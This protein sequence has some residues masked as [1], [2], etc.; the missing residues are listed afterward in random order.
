VTKLWP[1]VLNKEQF[2]AIL[3]APV[4][5][6][7]EWMKR[8]VLVPM[9]RTSANAGSYLFHRDDLALGAVILKLQE[10]LGE[11]NPLVFEIAEQVRPRVRGWLH[12]GHNP[13]VAGPLKITIKAALA[14]G[15]VLPVTLVIPAEV[16]EGVVV[17]LEAV[18]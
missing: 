3:D 8:G 16:F 1:S 5:Q 13:A 2:A 15:G 11:K 14:G 17:R 9:E 10:V 7:R 18:A 4:S 6:V 12:W